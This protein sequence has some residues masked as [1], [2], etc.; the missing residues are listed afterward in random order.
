M[1]E[2]V[3]RF[4]ALRHRDFRLVWAS[5]FVSIVGTQMQLVA[6]NWHIYTLLAGATLS[7]P[8]F[9][10]SLALSPEALGLGGVGL[11]RVIPI[12]LF[13]LIGGNL[14]DIA[15]RRTL[16]IWTNAV[17]AGLA[18]S[19]AVAN[20]A[21][22]DALWVI[23]L[24]TALT[25]ATAAFSGPA[26]Q[27]L[28]PNLVP[29]EHLTNAISLNSIVFQAATITG[30]ALAG[31]MMSR[32]N[33]GWVYVVNALSFGAI[34]VALAL[35]RYR[36]GRAAVD[37]GLNVKAIA[38][39]WRFVRGTRI[40]W[41]SMLLD[42]FATFFSSARTMLPLVAGQI[43]NV[44]AQGYGILATADAVGSLIAGSA[45]SLRKD[46]YRQG[47]VLLGSV[48]LYGLATALFGLSTSFAVSYLLFMF[49][50]ASD[51]VSTVIR[52]TIR[53]VMTPDRLRGRMTGINQ[54]FFMGG[55]QL[56]ELEAGLIAALL[57]VPFA[58]VSGGVATIAMA[59]VIAWRYP[60][61]RNYTSATLEADQQRAAAQNR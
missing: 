46:I 35:L 22:H 55:P 13:A 8:F 9:G 39:G 20:F 26:F 11:V 21:G 57:G 14:A 23:Y 42:F 51:T 32:L 24:L 19:L 1:A 53:Q 10:R 60:R 2:P 5:N 40:I 27:S 41:G 48:A 28:I 25:S 52:Q 54:I 31:L 44:G 50:G 7:I 33:V 37:T 59:G 49:V 17:A 29:R 61:L 4:V 16:L 18:L 6:I 30:P 38:E 43:L 15:N 12:A 34:I 58:I 36:G 45:I 3:E 56:G 47:T